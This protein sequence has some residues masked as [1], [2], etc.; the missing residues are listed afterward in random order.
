M[1][2]VTSNEFKSKPNLESHRVHNYTTSRYERKKKKKN[3][4]ILYQSK[5]RETIKS[6]I[7][8]PLTTPKFT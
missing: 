4:D 5:R 1:V 8:M 7:F 6:D 2:A 3:T